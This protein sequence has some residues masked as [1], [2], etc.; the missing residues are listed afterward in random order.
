MNQTISIASDNDAYVTNV[1]DFDGYG[2]RLSY[3]RQRYGRNTA[4]LIPVG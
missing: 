4:F 3:R 2:F 1:I